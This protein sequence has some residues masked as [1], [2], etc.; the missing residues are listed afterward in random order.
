M[1]VSSSKAKDTQELNNTTE[2]KKV[3]E[4]CL[5]PCDM[6]FKDILTQQ[7]SLP[8]GKSDS[9]SSIS[10]GDS[11]LSGKDLKSA[12]NY[13]TFSMDKDDAKFFVDM[14]HDGQF[15]LN[16]QGE[17]NASVMQLDAASEIK[18][19]KSANVSKTLVN[20]IED[21]YNKQKPVRI[22]FDNNVSVVLKIDKAGKVTAEFI[23][24]DE[25][26]EQYLRNNIA[27]LKQSFDDKDLPYNDLLYR[28]HK[29]QNKK[30]NKG[31]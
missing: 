12:F 18:T 16:L 24:G 1:K 23:P 8:L 9:L 2:K 13:D 31:E 30:K 27:S 20:L 11:I 17:V 14:V 7:G 3:D 15:S 19:Y 26:V 22:D 25:A 21:S 10:S 5:C 29:Q 6:G 28:Q 4:P